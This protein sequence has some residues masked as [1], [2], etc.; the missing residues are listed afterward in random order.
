M[1]SD[2]ICFKME[3]KVRAELPSLLVDE[4]NYS[5]E[6]FGIQLGVHL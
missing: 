1:I 5:L 4:S 6:V 3:S 2:R